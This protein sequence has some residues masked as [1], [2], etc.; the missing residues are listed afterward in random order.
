MDP[1]AGNKGT[2]LK[3]HT[4]HVLADRRRPLVMRP[5]QYSRASDTNRKRVPQGLALKTS[6]ASAYEEE[7]DRSC[8]K[9][10]ITN[11]HGE[12]VKAGTRVRSES[13][14]SSRY[15]RE[16]IHYNNGRRKGNM[17]ENMEMCVNVVG[18]IVSS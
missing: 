13:Y 16:S 11:K 9:K 2:M 4:C 7:R 18:L 3:S 10:N 12:Q 6:P 15:G 14:S 5:P 1:C 17:E 8:S